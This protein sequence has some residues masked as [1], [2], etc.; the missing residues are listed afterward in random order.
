MLRAVGLVLLGLGTALGGVLI[1]L[2]PFLNIF[3]GW[4]LSPILVV[5]GI[6]T[7]LEGVSIE[8]WEVLKKG[9][10]SAV[11]LLFREEEQ[12]R[13]SFHHRVMNERLWKLLG[14][15]NCR[16]KAV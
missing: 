5:V 13:P 8:A 11:C 4:W 7:M 1:A 6:A 14:G 3:L 2:T 15:G 16:S 9:L 12:G 10:R